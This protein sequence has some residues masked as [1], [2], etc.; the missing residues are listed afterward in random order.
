MWIWKERELL[1]QI[2]RYLYESTNSSSELSK[3]VI[4]EIEV[5]T[6]R[7]RLKTMHLVFLCVSEK[8]KIGEGMLDVVKALLQGVQ[9]RIQGGAKYVQDSVIYI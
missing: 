8:V 1:S 6:G 2:P 5:L 3:V 9:S 7:F 4:L